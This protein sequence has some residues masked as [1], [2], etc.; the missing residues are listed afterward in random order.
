MN[1][2]LFYPFIVVFNGVERPQ[3]KIVPVITFIITAHQALFIS[4]NGNMTNKNSLSCYQDT[5]NCQLL[6]LEV[7]PILEKLKLLT[8][9]KP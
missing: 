1:A 6:C 9:T 4:L 5:R 2:T 8:F 3:N 7:F